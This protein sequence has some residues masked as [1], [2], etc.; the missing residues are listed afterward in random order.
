MAYDRNPR[1][2]EDR[3]FVDAARR[4]TDLLWE[5][6]GGDLSSFPR[7]YLET[8]QHEFAEG[9]ISMLE[10]IDRIDLGSD[11][12]YEDYCEVVDKLMCVDP[13]SWPN[14]DNVIETPSSLLFEI[15]P[16]Y[17][18]SEFD[19][20][21]EVLEEAAVIKGPGESVA[22]EGVVAE[23]G[24]PDPLSSKMET[25]FKKVIAS[26][27][28]DGVSEVTD[29]QGNP[30][31]ESNNYLMAPDGKSFSGIFYDSP[32][33]DQAKKFPFVIS[34]GQQGVWQIKY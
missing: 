33:N 3:A 20:A 26:V 30:P 27:Y 16:D 18:F 10:I 15:E 14:P 5:T 6:T 9:S 17:D 12:T 1:F 29:P 8:L 23:Q 19:F 34:E 11:A 28:L 7:S 25:F 22:E 4:V 21:D 2:G 32:P 13:G 24:A 31:S